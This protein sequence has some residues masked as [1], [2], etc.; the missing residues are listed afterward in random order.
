MPFS[1]YPSEKLIV[2]S[3]VVPTVKAE[4]IESITPVPIM[5]LSIGNPPQRRSLCLWGFQ[6]RNAVYCTGEWRIF[7]LRHKAAGALP[8]SR[9]GRCSKAAALCLP[10]PRHDSN[11]IL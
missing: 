5:I 4:K 8:H 10:C 9:G 11:E 1:Y 3:P 2:L 6:E 7:F